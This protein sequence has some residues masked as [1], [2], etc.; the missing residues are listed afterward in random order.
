VR[1]T[2]FLNAILKTIIMKEG[3]AYSGS[4]M[5]RTAVSARRV[6]P[7]D[8]LYENLT[9]NGSPEPVDLIFVI[10]GRMERKQYGLDLYRAGFA[11]R[12]LLSIGR[13]EVSKM[14]AIDF[15]ALDELIRLRNG[16]RP[17]ERHFFCEINA[18][19]IQI[20][21]V[22]L[23]RWSTYGELLALRDRLEC[24]QARSLIIVSTDVHLRRIAV[25]VE[26][27]F[28]GVP[29]KFVYC[30]VP[31]RYCFLRKEK[32]WIRRT[33]RWFVIKEAI[34]LLGYRV[35]LSLPDWAVQRCMRL[36]G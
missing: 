12:L 16:T 35:I 4:S 15:G 5:H 30:P 22:S 20:E 17:D 24:G 2:E 28:R 1:R 23:P 11:P 3:R 10:A 26:R 18:S 8:R 7:L 21:K 32:W 29:L 36:S 34:K 9:R 13:F 19:G 25:S 14:P 6:S 27:I 33:D 31:E